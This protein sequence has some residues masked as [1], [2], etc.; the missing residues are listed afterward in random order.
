MA[1]NEPK[2]TSDSHP[3]LHFQEKR[4]RLANKM[5]ELK[6]KGKRVMENIGEK[7]TDIIQKWEEKSR[8]IIDTFLHLFGGEGRLVSSPTGPS[9]E[10]QVRR[11]RQIPSLA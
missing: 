4:L 7:R 11:A 9:F 3:A 5:D 1:E 2:P 10:L 8:D 6:T